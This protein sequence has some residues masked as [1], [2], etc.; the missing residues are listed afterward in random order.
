MDINNKIDFLHPDDKLP[1][2]PPFTQLSQATGWGLMQAGIPEMH[3]QTLGEG[4]KIA[5]LD[6][7]SSDHI[8]LFENVVES[9]DATGNGNHVDVQGHST[10]VAGIIAAADN[11]EGI[12][13]VAPKSKIYFVKVLDN[14]GQGGY[15]A[16]EA[17]IRKAIEWGVDIINMSLGSPSEPSSS[18]HQAIIDAHNAGIFIVAAAGNDSGA[19]NYPARYNEV[20]AVGAINP[21]GDL[22]PFSSVGDEI[23]VVA[24]GESIYST[25]PVNKYATL[26]GTSQAAPFIS[27][28]VALVLA[29]R[30]AHTDLPPIKTLPELFAELD[31]LC[32]PKGRI[33]D[34][35]MG[36]VGFGIPRGHNYFGS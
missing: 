3:K 30:R 33:V 9:W 17:G 26:R 36:H 23:A 32:D 34:G 4:I 20:I 7:G 28:L 12:L 8:D 18:L 25:W 22:C 21:N 1:I 24:A 16:I 2:F 29:Y 15:Q 13:G 11:A 27:G 14:N 19:V 31:K 35:K 10:H 5:V 6:T